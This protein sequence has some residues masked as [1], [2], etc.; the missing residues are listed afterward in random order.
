[1]LT[2]V[3]SARTS[4]SSSSRRLC[5][6]RRSDFCCSLGLGLKS[7]G[8]SCFVTRLHLLVVTLALVV[9][10]TISKPMIQMDPNILR[11]QMQPIEM[12]L[13]SM[14][15]EHHLAHLG[16][17]METDNSAASLS[18]T[19]VAGCTVSRAPSESV[20]LETSTC[21]GTPL[22]TTLSAVSGIAF[23]V[24]PSLP[25]MRREKELSGSH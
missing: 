16:Y 21:G 5:F 8:T 23:Y 24:I 1:M 10:T 4:C 25:G 14:T 13:R 7:R 15:N 3:H 20:R 9:P 22:S 11:G 12:M 19:I 6:G 2:L 17:L 18:S